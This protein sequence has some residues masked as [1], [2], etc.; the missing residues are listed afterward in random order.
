MKVTLRVALLLLTL[1]AIAAA[2]A[3]AVRAADEPT[4]GGTLSAAGNTITVYSN[5]NVPARVSMSAESVTLSRTE[6]TILPGETVNLTF[7]GRAVGHVSATYTIIPVAGQE[8][9]SAT[10]T[11][12]LEPVTPPPPPFDPTPFGIG[13][14]AITGL[15]LLWRRVRPDKWRIVRV[16]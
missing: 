5:G 1:A 7:S 2:G 6:F 15:L 13:F 8:T 14:V 3:G 10:L 9:G 4:V 11:L 12:G 16:A